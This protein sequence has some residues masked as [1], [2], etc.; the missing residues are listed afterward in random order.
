MPGL[1]LVFP[2]CQ[3]E[4]VAPLVQHG[5]MWRGREGATLLPAIER[6]R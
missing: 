2:R 4:P 1:R 5:H 6:A 3:Q